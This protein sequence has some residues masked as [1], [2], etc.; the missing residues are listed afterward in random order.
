[1]DWKKVIIAGFF[2]GLWLL[3]IVLIVGWIVNFVAP[4]AILDLP[5]M[6][7]VDDPVAALFFAYP[8]VI[9]FMAAI[10]YATIQKP[11]MSLA[12]T[13]GLLFGGI[14]IMLYS[15]PCLFV[16][17]TSMEYPP[18]FYLSQILEGVIGFP[19]LGL[20][21]AKIWSIKPGTHS[22]DSSM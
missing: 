11:L 12:G 3:C 16:T 18:G 17:F 9:S 15:I 13:P 21:Y 7:S 4:Y 2:G 22:R 14:L 5:G 19:L 10:V 20:L 8:F 6:R 1:M